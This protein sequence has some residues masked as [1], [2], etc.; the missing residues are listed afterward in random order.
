MTLFY[1]TIKLQEKCFYIGTWNLGWSKSVIPGYSDSTWPQHMALFLGGGTWH[2]HFLG[3]TAS[4]LLGSKQTHCL[5]PSVALSADICAHPLLDELKNPYPWTP[6][7]APWCATHRVWSTKQH[8]SQIMSS[9][10][11]IISMRCHAVPW[12]ADILSHLV[13]PL[14][15]MVMGYLCAMTDSLWQWPHREEGIW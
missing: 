11:L 13:A 7:A 4:I 3:K 8:T 15:S 2:K 9:M 1:K 5:A 6:W 12:L 10:N 14:R